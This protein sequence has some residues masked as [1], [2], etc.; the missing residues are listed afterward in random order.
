MTD[1]IG[2]HQRNVQTARHFHRGLIAGFFFTVVV[3]LQFH[4]DV[5]AAENSG[6]AVQCFASRA[7]FQT[8]CQRTLFAT[9]E[10]HQAFGKLFEVSRR[11]GWFVSRLCVLRTRA[12]FHARDQATQIPVTGLRFHQQQVP[13]AIHRGNFGTHVRLNAEFLCCGMKT[14]R[15]I[16]TID[17]GK[18]HGG[19]TGGCADGRIINGSTGAAQEAESRACVKFNVLSHQSRG[20]HQS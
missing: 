5:V 4:I 8:A 15:A 18:R 7:V 16:D 17:I 11:R 12:Q 1:A 9:R 13:A 14:C 2:S 6:K 20:F 19:R 3:T 10:T